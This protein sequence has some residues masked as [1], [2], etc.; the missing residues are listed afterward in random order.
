MGGDVGIAQDRVVR[1]VGAR[2]PGPWQAE[3]PVDVTVVL[4]RRG[5][6]PAVAGWPQPAALSRPDFSYRCGA[7][8]VDI[9]HLR[10]FATTHGL[11]EIGCQPH[12]RVLYWRAPAAVL[13]RAF[14]VR[15]VLQP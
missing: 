7:D 2:E 6:P 14:G 15:L 9:E 1:E 8:P 4:R 10:A 13:E 3:K 12:R 5:E 11:Q